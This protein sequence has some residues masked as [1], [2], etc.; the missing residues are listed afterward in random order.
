MPRSALLLRLKRCLRSDEKENRCSNL[1]RVAL[2]DEFCYT[3]NMKYFVKTLQ[4][5]F[6]KNGAKKW[7]YFLLF[8]LIPAALCAHAVPLYRIFFIIKDTDT[9]TFGSI[10]I[11]FFSYKGVIL[12]FFVG[13]LCNV[14]ISACIS[15]SL[16]YHMKIGQFSLPRFFTS[17]NNNFFSCFGRNAT[18]ALAILFF[19]TVFVLF[20]ALWNVVLNSIA[21]VIASAFMFAV[22]FILL[23][24][25]LSTLTLW[26]PT[27]VLTGEKY[28]KALTT[29]FYQ[30]RDKHKSFFSFYLIL[31]VFLTAFAVI[32]YYTS[33]KPLVSWAITTVSYMVAIIF[34]HVYRF[35]AFFDFNNL[36][37]ADLAVSSFKRR[38]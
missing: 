5:L 19:Y 15:S 8:S 20:D 13:F 1:V 30:S 21:A 17:I 32:A 3:E 18:L 23:T 37:R 31:I 28:Q 6:S 2:F 7:L 38:L 10:W 36:T 16:T 24:Y 35:V 22:L 33:K 26:L 25:I 4:Y 29:A 11:S 9:P 34:A 27:M 12:S 14:F